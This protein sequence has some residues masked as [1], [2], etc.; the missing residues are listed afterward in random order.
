MPNYIKQVG[1]FHNFVVD[2]EMILPLIFCRLQNQQSDTQTNY[3][4]VMER[5]RHP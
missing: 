3:L 4:P 2:L 5:E 1:N